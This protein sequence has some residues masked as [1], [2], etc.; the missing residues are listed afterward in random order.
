V[1]TVDRQGSTSDTW[2]AIFDTGGKKLVVKAGAT[3]DTGPFTSFVSRPGIEIHTTCEI[4]IDHLG[5]I[6]I[7]TKFG[8]NGPI[9][10]SADGDIRVDGLVRSRTRDSGVPG[11]VTLA[12]CC[13]DITVGRRGVV[14]T[15]AGNWGDD[16]VQGG[17]DVN[18]VTCCDIPGDILVEGLVIAQANAVP[19]GTERP[20]INVFS[21]AGTVTI[22]GNSPAPLRD[23]YSPDQN[24][25]RKFDL[26]GGL[27]SWV[28]HDFVAGTVN[29]QARGDVIVRGHGPGNGP[30][31]TYG[32][33]AAGSI[34]HPTDTARPRAGTIDVR[35]LEGRIV[36]ENRA[37]ELIGRDNDGV[38]L[39]LQS[40]QALLITNT[41][42][43]TFNPVVDAA[44]SFRGGDNVLRSFAAGITVA[45]GAT[46]IS[47][48]GGANS[49]TSCAG[50]S[51]NAGA[52]SPAENPSDNS[53]VCTAG[54]EPL[55]MDCSQFLPE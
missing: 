22:N 38:E 10:L 16:V 30:G 50:V 44:G 12:S 5:A 41:G 3:I 6:D 26:F 55:F 40:S 15:D 27:L 21:S 53:G 52:V 54:P 47:S 37:F 28:T 2:K 8:N 9:L 17:S 51:Y 25:S 20:D 24:G 23:N 39:R 1:L 49:L 29:I 31:P 34:A 46:I 18:L 32:A 33:V 19:P 35:S 42:G 14:E 43:P 48:S 11:N 36:A 7:G 4:Q 13:G 45:P